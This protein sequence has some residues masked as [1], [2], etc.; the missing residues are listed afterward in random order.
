LVAAETYGSLGQALAAK[1][2]TPPSIPRTFDTVA[3]SI[4]AQQGTFQSLE[5]IR[6]SNGRAVT[7]G[8]E[9]MLRWQRMLAAQEGLYGEPAAVAPLVALEMLRR[10]GVVQSHESAAILFTAAGLK[11][12]AATERSL[13]ECPVVSAEFSSALR[14]LEEHYRF[15]ATK[16]TTP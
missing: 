16:G 12:P 14:A 3:L 15:D 13:G 9:D 2:D 1:S 11:D 10:D 8:N 6:R 7:V 5:A 4:G